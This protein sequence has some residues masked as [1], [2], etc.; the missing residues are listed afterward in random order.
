MWKHILGSKI[1]AE[2]VGGYPRDGSGLALAV[3][4]VNVNVVVVCVGICVRCADRTWRKVQLKGH[5]F[6]LHLREPD[7]GLNSG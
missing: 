7:L 6:R 5:G 4:D 1:E 3:A 2:L